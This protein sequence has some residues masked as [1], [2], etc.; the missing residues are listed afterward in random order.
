MKTVPPPA[1][2]DERQTHL[3]NV[4]GKPCESVICEECSE[5]IRM[6]T[7][8]RRKREEQGNAWSPWE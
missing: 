6:E 2:H 3:C 5:R 4:C 8:S 7:L 1:P